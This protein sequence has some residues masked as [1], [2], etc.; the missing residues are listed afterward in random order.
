MGSPSYIEK[1]G[2]PYSRR[3]FK[4]ILPE[5]YRIPFIINKLCGF[6]KTTVGQ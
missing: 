2:E 6:L 3:L 5:N 1:E 4:S